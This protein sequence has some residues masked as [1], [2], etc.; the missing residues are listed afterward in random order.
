MRQTRLFRTPAL[1]EKGGLLRDTA[2]ESDL[3]HVSRVSHS[4]FSFFLKI[5]SPEWLLLVEA[6]ALKGKIL[7]TG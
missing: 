2:A 5:Q 4:Y 6:G 3:L 1:L 7:T